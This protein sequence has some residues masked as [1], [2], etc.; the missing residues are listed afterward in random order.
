MR[1]IGADFVALCNTEFDVLK[2][3]GICFDG[4]GILE[5]APYAQLC[6]KY[7]NIEGERYTNII[8]KCKNVIKV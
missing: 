2:Q 6:E 7:K 1:I 3:G 5:I 8:E 4:N